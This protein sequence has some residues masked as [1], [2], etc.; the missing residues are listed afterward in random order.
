MRMSRLFRKLLR[1]V[2]GEDAAT[3][4]EYAVMLLVITL[5]LLSAIQVLGPVLEDTFSLQANALDTESGL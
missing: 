3:A 2:R 4:V 1:F 5:T